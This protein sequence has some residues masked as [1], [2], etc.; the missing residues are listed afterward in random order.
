VINLFSL[1]LTTFIHSA[2][3]DKIKALPVYHTDQKL[4]D[5]LIDVR[6]LQA[7]DVKFLQTRPT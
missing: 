7:M 5:G 1:L 3:K 4:D 6:K 2:E